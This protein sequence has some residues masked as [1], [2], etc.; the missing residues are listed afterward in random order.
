MCSSDLKTT[1]NAKNSLES[2]YDA[3]LQVAA[4]VGAL[5]HDPRY[6]FQIENALVVVVNKDGVPATALK[7]SK[8][9]LKKYW[10]QW[11]E[12]CHRFHQMQ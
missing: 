2:T 10:L 7:M 5:N 1:K 3:P 12:R 4:Y 11:V 6:P 8:T 9:L